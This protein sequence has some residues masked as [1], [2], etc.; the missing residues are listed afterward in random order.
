MKLS[1]LM[2]VYNERATI[3]E[4][5]RRVQA[6]P[7]EK[8]IVVVDNCSDDGTRAIL[9]GWVADGLA[10][11]AHQSTLEG[12]VTGG[13]RIH[14]QKENRGKGAS[15]RRALNLARGEWVIVQDAD[16]EYDPRDYVKLLA[17]A[18]K[19]RRPLAVFGTR[20][21]RGTLARK[22]QPRTSF[23]FGRVGLSIVFRLLFARPL[24]DVATCY[25]LMPRHLA[26]SLTLQGDG[27]DL[28]FEIAARLVRRGV[29]IREVP[30]SYVPRDASQGKKIRVVRDGLRAAWTL[31][32][33]RLV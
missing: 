21:G 27:F 31:L 4:I 33:Y 3:E 7:I 18:E 30:I 6:V 13:L 1:V 22:N 28:D 17:V 23:F 16:L 5:V 11:W 12:A 24:S 9:S 8:E 25:K 15:V 26:Q 14:F 29:P 2:P 20:L 19:A 32:K 10:S